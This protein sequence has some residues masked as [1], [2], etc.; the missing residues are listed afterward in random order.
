MT[1][2]LKLPIMAV[3]ILGASAAA[4]YFFFSGNNKNSS[5]Q[6]EDFEDGI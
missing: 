6:N 1:T 2:Y 4:L 3:A 5:Q